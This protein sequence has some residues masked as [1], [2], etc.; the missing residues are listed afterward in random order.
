[1]VHLAV[2]KDERMSLKRRTLMGA[3]TA[4]ALALAAPGLA[5]A[6]LANV[7][8]WVQSG[9]EAEALGEV[10]KAY[11]ENTG[12]PVTISPQGRAGWRQRYETALAAGSTEFDGVLHISRFVPALAAG[13]LIAPYD[14]YIA[15]AAEYDA[16]DF[17]EIIQSEMK[18]DG[19]WYMM[20][21]DITL[22]TLVY[23]TDLIPEA[24]ETWD[25][26]REN[27]LKFTQSHNPD[28]PTKYG[29]AYAGSPGNVMAAFLGIMGGHGG[30][31]LDSQS[32]VTTDSPEVTAAWKMFVDMKN[33][34][35]VTPPDINAW[36]YPELLVGLQ[37][38]TLAQAQ[39]FTAGM[40][41][42]NDCAQSPDVCENLALVA[43]PEGPMGSKTRVNPLGVMMNAQSPNKDALWAFLEFATGK[44]GGVIYSKAGGQSPRSSVLANEEVAS[45]RPW[46][47][48]VLK[49]SKAGMGTLRIAESR[50]VAEAFDR[51]AQQ[52]IAG[53]ITPE[54]SL[55]KAAEEMRAILGGC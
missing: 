2:N 39:F 9:P 11:T 48:E 6:E 26:L 14:D 20:P 50:E 27:A 53:Q 8:I 25:D 31:F 3:G 36:D 41:I 18:Y 51:Y 35:K 7:T 24:P 40:P 52:A 47:P 21:T 38:G 12:N 33:E 17:P 5:Q 19:T 44:E 23:R 1:M 32:C 45:E 22:E 49:A 42:L 4:I 30:D 16:D 43:Q 29:F 34:D 55:I 54:E 28:S 37:N 46:V 15:G 10:A 13:G